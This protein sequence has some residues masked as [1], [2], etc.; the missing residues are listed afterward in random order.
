[1]RSPTY[2][3]LASSSSW[4]QAHENILCPT[5]WARPKSCVISFAFSWINLCRWM[6]TIFSNVKTTRGRRRVHNEGVP[7]WAQDFGALAFYTP[8]PCGPTKIHFNCVLKLA[9]KINMNGFKLI[10]FS[11]RTN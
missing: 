2:I 5:S 1:M 11:V 4:R 3:I 7:S 10:I 9:P 6:H 8:F